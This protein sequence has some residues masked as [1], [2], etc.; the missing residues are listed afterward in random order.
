MVDITMRE[1]LEA[2]VHFGHQKRY[3]NPKMA[4]YIYG[5]RNGIH[6]IHL[7]KTLPLFREALAFLEEVAANG[8]VVLFVGTKRTASEAVTEEASRCSMPFVNQRWI[9]GTLTNFK[10]IRGSV[11][12]LKELERMRDEGLLAQYTKKEAL[13]LMRELE[14]L[15]RALGGIKEMDALPDALF[16]IDVSYEETAVREAKKL[17]I[18]I[19]AVVD[20]NGD[21]EGIDY[22]I[23]G[24]D[25]AIRANR[26]YCHK[27]STA[28]LEG[29]ASRLAEVASE[30]AFFEEVP[31][32]L[33]QT[34][35]QKEASRQGEEAETAARSSNG[36]NE[37]VPR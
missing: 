5:V 22:P 8:G 12:R 16:V 34:A 36:S 7:E 29:R 30:E 4:P 15:E 1:L 2:G 18:P 33:A 32:P 19:V 28:I 13:R 9:G 14:K 10:T 24:N 26:L 31:E 23:P 25:D 37:P 6:I 17:R 20:T 27:V 3:W 35:A 11:E 21:P